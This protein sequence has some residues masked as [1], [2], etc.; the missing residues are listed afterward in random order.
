MSN[1]EWSGESAT[2]WLSQS[3]WLDRQITPVSDL[4]FDLASLQTGERV[5]DVGCGTGPTTRVAAGLVGSSGSVTGID[6]SLDLLAAASAHDVP[7]DAAHI[8]WVHADV[9]SWEPT[10]EAVDAV[11]SRFGVMFFSDPR[12]AFSNLRRATRPG[13]RLRVT[14]WDRRDRSEMWEVPLSTTLAVLARQGVSIQPLPVDG[15]PFSFGDSA[16]VVRMVEE[17]GWS[18]VAL[19]V[20]LL[21]FP[22]AGGVGPAAAARAAMSIGPTRLIVANLDAQL[23]GAVHDALTDELAGH[24]DDTGHVVLGGSVIA[25]SATRR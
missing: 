14:A 8:E 17:A 2:R 12:T 24:V 19:E 25:V 5:L 6:Q 18:E 15:G 4:L 9:V 20:H 16:E 10:I 11:I 23:Q 22:V 13:G 21:G 7:D 1:Y 3:D